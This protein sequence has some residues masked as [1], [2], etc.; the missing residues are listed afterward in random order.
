MTQLD[1]HKL[2]REDHG[3]EEFEVMEALL[4]SARVGRIGVIAQGEPYVIPMNFAYEASKIYIHGANQG[5]LIEAIQANPRIC[6]EIDQ[7]IATIPDP[8][9]CEFDTA[10]AS[11]ICYG[12]ARVIDD[13]KERTAALKVI[14]RKY[15]PENQA[16]S[17]QEVTVSQFAGAFESRTAVVEISVESMTGKKQDFVVQDI[18]PKENE[19]LQRM[20]L[21]EYGNVP[22]E[23]QHHE[24]V[25]AP[26]RPLELESGILKWYEIRRPENVIPLEYIRE[27]RNFLRDESKAGK[28]DLPYRLGFVLLHYSVT[29]SYL[30]VCYWD[31]YQELWQRNYIKRHD[32]RE[33]RSRTPA[34]DSPTFCVWELTPVWHEREA[35]VTFLNSDRSEDAKIRYLEDQFSGLK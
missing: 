31:G 7:Y 15:A 33:F 32:E 26:G 3:I 5:R 29:E 25:V 4:H 30:I 11:V 6:F 9:L 19:K 8:V 18:N 1:H 20:D 21:S 34:I 13:L 27:V 2:R 14:A 22:V 16:E 35:W 10:Y 24:R 12:T 28:F 23:Y 17:L